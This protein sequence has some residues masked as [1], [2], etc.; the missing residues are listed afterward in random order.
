MAIA[1]TMVWE[2]DAATG[3]DA[4][5]GGFDATA[6]TPGTNYAWGVGQ[7]VYALTSLANVAG[8]WTKATC[9]SRAFTAADVGNV[10]NVT[11]GTG[12]TAGR[13]QI[14]SVAGTTATFD[15]AIGTGADSTNGTGNLGGSLASIVAA[16]IQT[17]T[18]PVVAGNKLYIK[19]NAAA[20]ALPS[21]ITAGTA[22]T[23]VLPVL[24]AGYY[25]SHDDNPTIASGQ[26]PTIA[27]STYNWALA[28]SWLLRNTTHTFATTSSTYG[29]NGTRVTD[30]K[31]THTS[32]GYGLNVT[33]MIGCEY[34]GGTGAIGCL[35]GA[36]GA[37]GCYFHDAGNASGAVYYNGGAITDC[38]FDT[39][40]L[41]VN[42]SSTA[43][44]CVTDNTFINCLK[45]IGATTA[46][47]CG[48]IGNI[49][50]FCGTGVKWDTTTQTTVMW[51]N[52]FYG[53]DTAT[54]GIP[55]GSFAPAGGQTSDP[56]FT[57]STATGTTAT[58]NGAPGTTFTATGLL[59]DV[60]TTD[61][62]CVWSGTGA[63]PG[64]YAISSVAGAPNSITLATSP[65]ASASAIKWGIVKGGTATDLSIGTNLRNLGYPSAFP[66]CSTVAYLDIGA[67]QH[68]M[69]TTLPHGTLAQNLYAGAHVIDATDTTGTLHASNIATAKGSGDN[70]AAADLA[71]GKTVDDVA[72]EAAGGGYTYGDNSADKV[73]TTA[74]GAGTYQ[75]VATTDVKKNVAVGVSPA[76][77]SLEGIIDSAANVTTVGC[78]VSGTR[79]AYGTVS[80]GG[81]YAAA[82][83]VYD[84][85]TVSSSGTLTSGGA[86]NATGILYAAASFAANGVL[87]SDGS[88]KTLAATDS[89]PYVAGAAAQ[90][91]TDK[92]AV[93]GNK[94]KVQKGQ[95]VLTGADAG[96]LV[97]CVDSAGVNQGAG[98]LDESYVYHSW[99]IQDDDGVFKGTAGI[100]DN[101]VNYYATGT[102]DSG[103]DYHA[104]GVIYGAGSYATEAS[105]NNATAGAAQILSTYSITI[106]GVTTNG[107]ATAEAHTANQVLKSA[108]GNYNDDNLAVGNVR[109]V[110]FGLSQTGTLANL[111][112]TDAAYVALEEARNDA[113]TTT[114]DEILNGYSVKIRNVDING[115]YVEP[116]A[117]AY[118]AL[119]DG[120][121]PGGLTAGTLAAAKIMDVTY[122]TLAASSVLVAAGG[123]FDE[124]A[125][126]TDPGEANVASG[127]GYKIL[128]VSKSGS[129]VVTPASG[130]LLVNPGMT[131]G[132]GG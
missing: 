67:V 61:Y 128:N 116:I 75:P 11:G 45:G 108:G 79:Y 113:I 117:A 81:A 60:Q 58:T 14:L 41:G 85:G 28:A 19:Y 64:V 82:G 107:S 125:R 63:T 20:Y 24:V 72:G 87:E 13:Y 68:K 124:S 103:G 130:G 69:T 29:I 106:A 48:V 94:A 119:G 26:Q 70:L 122:G 112:A 8:D 92:A 5:G 7:A 96:T 6:G 52:A 1:A 18:S 22:G 42:F 88:Y 38:I 32:S 3:N 50:A 12:F 80:S 62:L 104:T 30:C 121:G 84:S 65:G 71:T 15:R 23:A 129:L 114:A 86:Y 76:V 74:T 17:A 34:S 73:L 57:T 120:Y 44:C 95:V 36:L 49:F 10:L 118:S 110:A 100:L 99:G 83:I 115:S 4:N 25:A 97:G 37:V 90:L 109:P 55:T 78:L 54:S 27:H 131:G 46:T 16:F 126:N 77:G 102:I 93:S 43:S 40:Y 111:V 56:G 91:V 132:I 39:C 21:A 33:G 123:T 59:A 9:G 66:G 53:N 35:V 127:T 98:L 51:N 101:L 2:I 89:S 31:F 47:N 105:R